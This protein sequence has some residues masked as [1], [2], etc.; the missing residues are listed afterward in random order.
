MSGPADKLLRRE[1]G[2]LLSGV[3]DEITRI[4]PAAPQA[5]QAGSAAAAVLLATICAQ[6]L[7]LEQPAWAAVSAFMITQATAPAAWRRGLL[8][9]AGTAAGAALGVLLASWVLYDGVACVLLLMLAAFGGIL[10]MLTSRHGYAWLLGSMTMF[11]VLLGA[12]GDPSAALTTAVYRTLE[13]IV[14]SGIA[15]LTT[16]ALMPPVDATGPGPPAAPEPHVIRHAMRS[17]IAVG[18]VPLAWIWLELPGLSQMAVTVAAVMAVPTLTGH[19]ADDS[20][21]VLRRSLH[22]IAG[23]LI[24]GLAALAILALSL[25][26]YLPWLLALG[27]GVWAG[28]F[29]HAGGGPVAYVG[30]QGVVAF[31]VTLVQGPGPPAAIAPGIQRMAGILVGLLVLLIVNFVLTPD[32]EPAAVETDKAAA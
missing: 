21:I 13:V 20:A 30:T 17:A 25:Q 19:P 4:G 11:M 23:C 31:V 15:M 26:S 7:H 32:D 8:R 6:W 12:V 3:R 24:G 27:A 1:V 14:G 22:R 28:T 9:L 18:L 5:R 10:G 29:I 16:W 2:T